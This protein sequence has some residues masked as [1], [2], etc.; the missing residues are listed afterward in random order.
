MY[1]RVEQYL[2]CQKDGLYIRRIK[3]Y[4]GYAPPQ[5]VNLNKEWK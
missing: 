5:L 4:F 2:I 1:F 3:L